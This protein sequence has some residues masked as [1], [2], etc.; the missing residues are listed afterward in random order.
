MSDC[1]LCNY[2]IKDVSTNKRKAFIV[3]NSKYEHSKGLIEINSCVYDVYQCS[4]VLKSLGFEITIL[5]NK[6]LEHMEKEIDKFINN[7]EKDD[8]SLFFYSGH[9]VK[10][11]GKNFLALSNTDIKNLENTTFC[12]DKY[13]NK[14]HESKTSIDLVF[15]DCCRNELKS[16]YNNFKERIHLR[17]KKNMFIGFSTSDDETSET[18]DDD[19]MSIFT[20]HFLDVIL[21]KNVGIDEIMKYVRMKV[22]EETEGEQI[23]WSASCLTVNF[24]FNIQ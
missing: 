10:I 24:Y 16:H 5:L 17:A 4:K 21:Y 1:I 11:G 6:N 7:L 2:K 3:G 18:G 15:L 23:P 9:G 13:L 20:K 22:I 19:E 8:I 14:L 12:I